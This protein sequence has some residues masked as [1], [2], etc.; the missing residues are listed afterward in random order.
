MLVVRE[1]FTVATQTVTMCRLAEVRGDIQRQKIPMVW[2]ADQ[3]ISSV[4]PILSRPSAFKR[5][6]R[7]K[8]L[9]PL[10]YTRLKN[11]KK[12]AKY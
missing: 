1:H 5:S 12:C 9:F 11:R 3:R 10:S 8:K 6:Q 4:R 2:A 7:F